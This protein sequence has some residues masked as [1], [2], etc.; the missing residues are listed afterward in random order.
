MFSSGTF[1]PSESWTPMY[2]GPTF[3]FV[4]LWGTS[5]QPQ[6]IQWR[7]YGAAP[8]GYMAGSATVGPKTQIWFGLPSVVDFQVMP[9]NDAVLLSST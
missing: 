3:G 4:Y 6:K 7:A 9:A 5:V 8:F 1:C 2:V